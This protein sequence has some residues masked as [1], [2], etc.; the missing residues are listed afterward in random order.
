MKATVCAGHL[1]SW[2]S[3]RLKS[4]GISNGFDRKAQIRRVSPYNPAGLQVKYGRGTG[5]LEGLRRVDPDVLGGLVG[6]VFE[7]MRNGA[8][9][10][11]RVAWV[12]EIDL[13]P[14]PHLEAAAQD[15]APFFALVSDGLIAERG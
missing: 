1:T 6:D 7:P 3:S 4:F 9:E 2:S 5:A 14:D 8:R 15:H 13:I 12:K 10:A 11:N